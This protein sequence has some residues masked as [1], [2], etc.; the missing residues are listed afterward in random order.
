MTKEPELPILL[1]AVK[2]QMVNK[3][4]DDE[5]MRM[6]ITPLK[7]IVA[8]DIREALLKKQFIN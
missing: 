5:T 6:L 2:L 1:P 3:N 4:L 8:V 7:A